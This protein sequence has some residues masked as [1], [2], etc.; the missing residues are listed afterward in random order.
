[1]NAHRTDR[2][3]ARTGCVECSS[4][5]YCCIKAGGKHWKRVEDEYLLGRAIEVPTET[6]S[7]DNLFLFNIHV[8]DT[9]LAVLAGQLEPT[10]GTAD[11]ALA[12]WC[13]S[14]R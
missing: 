2:Q 12:L 3:V 8:R 11:S 13:V 14:A 4:P 6:G 5:S 9:R 7:G 1:M 10:S